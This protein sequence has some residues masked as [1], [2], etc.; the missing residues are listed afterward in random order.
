MSSAPICHIPGEKPEVVTPTN[1]MKA[2]PIAEPNMRSL[3]ATVNALRDMVHRLSGQDQSGQG[4]GTG[5]KAPQE[6]QKVQ[7]TEQK[8]TVKKE[9][10]YQ[11]NDKTSENWVEVEHINSLTMV[12]KNTGQTWTWNHERTPG[13]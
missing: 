13:K 9:R 10:I 5:L 2:I 1:T 6:K 4:Q 11:N 3:V 12:D 8:R 7:W